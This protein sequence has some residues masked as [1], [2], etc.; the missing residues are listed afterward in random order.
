MKFFHPG[1]ADEQEALAIFGPDETLN[2]HGRYLIATPHKTLEVD[3]SHVLSIE[4]FE[5]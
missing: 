2:P 3:Q 5:E 4:P 1:T